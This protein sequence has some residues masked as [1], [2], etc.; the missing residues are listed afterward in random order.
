MITFQRILLEKLYSDEALKQKITGIYSN[1]PNHARFPFIKIAS[2]QA[3]PW[4]A[5]DI[6]GRTIMTS[7]EI[8]SDE[9][10]SSQCFQITELLE[11]TLKN[12]ETFKSDILISKVK[13]LNNKI[14][15]IKAEQIWVSE[16]KVKFWIETIH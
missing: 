2:L 1:I 5:Q 6:D 12:L 3:E 14:L 11:K 8:A 15:Y 13:Q 10:S 9:E 7:F 16:L 4:V